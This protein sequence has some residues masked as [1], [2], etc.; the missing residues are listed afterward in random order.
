MVKT[1][2]N[3]NRLNSHSMNGKKYLDRSSSINEWLRW[4][5]ETQRKEVKSFE[6]LDFAISSFRVR[7]IRKQ[8]TKSNLV[9]HC[10]Y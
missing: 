7:G 3:F 6:S 2:M 10:T 8:K 9:V 1:L 4:R 5:R